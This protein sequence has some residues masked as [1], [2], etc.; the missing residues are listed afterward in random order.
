MEM[1]TGDM[2]TV[3]SHFEEIRVIS[4]NI[5]RGKVKSILGLLPKAASMHDVYIC[6]LYNLC[7]GIQ[8][9]I[10]TFKIFYHQLNKEN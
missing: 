10:F 4:L 8:G 6:K 1:Q 9:F 2:T 5:R 7:C 3:I